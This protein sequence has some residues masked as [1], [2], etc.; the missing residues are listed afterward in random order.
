[1]KPVLAQESQS[2]GRGS[3]NGHRFCQAHLVPQ[4]GF[5]RQCQTL[6]QGSLGAKFPESLEEI[7][8]GRVRE[9]LDTEKRDA[10]IIKSILKKVLIA[11]KRLHSLGGHC[12]FFLH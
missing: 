11:L 8:L 7:M 10:A 12:Y 6:L 1:M 3:L 2:S 9:N 4:T 5:F